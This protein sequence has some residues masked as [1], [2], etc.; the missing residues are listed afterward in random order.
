MLRPGVADLRARHA[1]LARHNAEA[2]G[3]AYCMLR[4]IDSPSLDEVPEE[5]PRGHVQAAG[6]LV[7][8]QRHRTT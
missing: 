1:A 6:G 5:T 4:A 7:E 3:L 8:E 2:E